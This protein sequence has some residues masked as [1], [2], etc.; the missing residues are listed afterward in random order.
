MCLTYYEKHEVEAYLKKLW[1][2]NFFKFKKISEWKGKHINDIYFDE[3][4][5]YSFRCYEWESCMYRMFEELIPHKFNQ[6]YLKPILEGYLDKLGKEDY[7]SKILKHIELCKIESS[8][9]KMG[10]WKFNFRPS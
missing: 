7:D 3:I 10:G 8:Y 4:G 2:D 1:K 5:S 9:D 6:Y